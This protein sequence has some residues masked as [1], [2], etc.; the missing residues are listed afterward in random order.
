MCCHPTHDHYAHVCVQAGAIAIAPGPRLGVNVL[1]VSGVSVRYGDGESGRNLFSDL[2]FSLPPA[3]VMGI[4][5]AN[6]VWIAIPLMTSLLCVAIPLMT[7]LL[8]A[9]PYH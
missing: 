2:T 1:D 8:C 7:S 9:L 3:A 4:I 5:G 6:G